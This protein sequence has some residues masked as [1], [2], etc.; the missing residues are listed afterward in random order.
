M[1][2][3][4]D[5][6][7]LVLVDVRLAFPSLFTPK[8]LDGKE[9]YES[10]YLLDKKSDKKQLSAIQDIIARLIDDEFDGE[11]PG[12]ERLPIQDGDKKA[13]DGYEGHFYLGANRSASQGRPTVLNK[14]KTPLVES[15][16]IIF[17][18]CYV[19]AVVRFYTING[20]NAKKKG[21]GGKRVCCSV[22]IVQFNHEGDRFGAPAVDIDVLP[23]ID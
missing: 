13:Y 3:Q 4:A 23:D 8:E 12:T 17:G 2:K 7:Q 22:E 19:N 15:D 20:K 11:S 6:N 10:T 16:G 1:A 14:D 9:R 21:P 18:G 5:P